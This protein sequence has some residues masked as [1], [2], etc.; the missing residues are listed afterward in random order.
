MLFRGA[1]QGLFRFQLDPAN[2][3]QDF[4]ACVKL[5]PN[6]SH[7]QAEID[8]TWKS[9]NQIKGGSVEVEVLS[10]KETFCKFDPPL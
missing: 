9:Y 5:A 4:T 10:E 3:Q 2:G 6:D 7:F 1:L 8:K